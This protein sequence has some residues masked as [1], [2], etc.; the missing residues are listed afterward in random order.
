MYLEGELKTLKDRLDL[1]A[2]INRPG[3]ST[4]FPELLLKANGTLKL[5]MDA[6]NNHGRAHLHLD[7]GKVHHAA[8]YAI[9][10]GDLLAGR[11]HRQYDKP[12][13]EWISTNQESLMKIWRALQSGEIPGRKLIVELKGSDFH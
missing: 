6:S 3:R 11:A 8:S 9:D 12:V 5:R 4:G 7:Y 2:T 10:T 1:I 13:R